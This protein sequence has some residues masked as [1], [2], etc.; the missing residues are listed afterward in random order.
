MSDIPVSDP[1]A[2]P[3]GAP[4]GAETVSPL[5]A[6]Q[7]E[8]DDLYDRLLRKTA[9]FDNFRKR[10]ERERREFA[11]WAAAELIGDVLAV[12]DRP[13]A[14]ARR[15]IAAHGVAPVS[16]THLDVYKRQRMHYS[17]AISVVDGAAVAVAR[18]LRDEN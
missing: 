18:F 13:P 4:E 3:P 2:T 14:F 1:S 11:E 7:R 17:R 16:Y 10:T 15:C 5:D 8:R 9:E 12:V 6:L